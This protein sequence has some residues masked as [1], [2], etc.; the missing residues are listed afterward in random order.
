MP[1]QIL[2]KDL[3]TAYSHPAL[4]MKAHT[5]CKPLSE[6]GRA[7]IELLPVEI[8]GEFGHQQQSCKR[9]L[10]LG[11]RPR[12]KTNISP[13]PRS[14]H[15]SPCHR[16]TYQWLCSPKQGPRVMSPR[17][18]NIPLCH[19]FNALRE[20]YIPSLYHLLEVPRSYLE[21]SPSG[22]VGKAVG[23]LAL[24]FSGLRENEADEP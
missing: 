24:H 13:S 7:P 14:N 23:L 4:D 20:R 18:A 11:R 17:L 9:H 1:A 15:P 5:N 3:T 19:S 12:F 2:V 22:R 10:A 6:M 21:K 16:Y 8:F